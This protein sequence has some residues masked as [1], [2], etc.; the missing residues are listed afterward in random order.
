MKVG[1]LRDSNI[2]IHL[3]LKQQR[4]R[5]PDLPVIYFVE[6]TL[7]NFKQIAT[8]A[9]KSLYD[10]FIVNFCKPVTPA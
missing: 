1:S 8:D 5:I 2:V 6:P 10:Y 9:T 7:E 3:N 4:E